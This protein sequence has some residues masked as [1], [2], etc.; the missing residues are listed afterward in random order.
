MVTEKDGVFIS[1]ITEEAAIAQVLKKYLK[2][3][4]GESLSVF[5]SSDYDSI[6][7]GE[8]WYGAI[9]NGLK[10]AQVLIVLLSRQSIDRR[11]INFEAGVGV[12]AEVRLL[13]MCI[14]GFKP[15]EVDLPIGQLHVRELGDPHSVS[16]MLG[17]IKIALQ[18]DL[19]ENAVG[20]FLEEVAG[21]EAVLPIRG[22]ALTPFLSRE[23]WGHQLTFQL[24]NTGNQP[25]RLAEIEV[26]I[27]SDLRAPDAPLIAMPP[28]RERIYAQ[29]DGRE[30]IGFRYKATAAMARV[31][32]EP[33]PEIFTPSM[34]SRPLGALNIA[35]R[36]LRGPDDYSRRIYMKVCTPDF[37]TEPTFATFE[38]AERNWEES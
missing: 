22:V 30:G 19:T 20:R 13:P 29:V 33:L 16:A 23:D 27:P 7:T 8:E 2:I 14:R 10:S 38:Q 4:F 32:I 5:V 26:L 31:P 18:R 12:G 36:R 9:M 1:H 15:A 37:H 25:V 11:W 3:W 6:V 24:S 17:A 35:M 34:T 28:I 21:A